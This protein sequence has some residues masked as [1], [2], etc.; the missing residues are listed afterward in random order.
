MATQ[1]QFRRGTTAQNGSF[2]GAAGEISINTTNNSLRVHDG[3]TQGG[4][5]LAKVDLSNHSSVGV[6]TATGFSGPLTGNVTGNATGLS[7]SPSITVTDITAAGNVSIAGT[8]TYED[9]TNIDSVGLITA[10]TG[11]KVLAGGINVI[12]VVTATNFNSSSDINLKENI[13]IIK[14]P[15]EKIIQ[16]NGITF[17]W[18]SDHRPS[19]GIIAQEVEKVLPEIVKENNGNKSVNYNGL[20]GLLV[21]SVKEQQERIDAL[22]KRIELLES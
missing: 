17:D 6:L 13:E 21:E 8:L 3:S 12:G 22:T 9:V 18:K 16:L 10:R 20:I 11:I 4:A 15:I 1:V 2:T 7:G 5:E 19:A 14:K